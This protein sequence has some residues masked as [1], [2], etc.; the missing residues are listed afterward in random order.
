MTDLT[1]ARRL[2]QRPRLPTQMDAVG[3]PQR[4]PDLGRISEAADRVSPDRV[5]GA[6]RRT[7]GVGGDHVTASERSRQLAAD[8]TQ[9]R[10]QLRAQTEAE[11]QRKADVLRRRHGVTRPTGNPTTGDHVVR[12]RPDPTDT[13]RRVERNVGVDHDTRKQMLEAEDGKRGR[14]R[15]ERPTLKET[16][17]K[18]TAPHM[19]PDK[20]PGATSRRVNVH[21]NGPE[22]GMPKT[23]NP[24]R[25]SRFRQ[26][27]SVVG[28]GLLRGMD[29]ALGL[30]WSLVP[31]GLIQQMVNPGNEA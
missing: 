9:R 24:S 28:K 26:G 30:A 25:M 27:L 12:G 6:A 22:K 20:E 8:R 14:G 13:Q 31:V 17:S 23:T 1:D 5:Q 10:D 16:P 7:T 15:V 29:R 2:E 4:T 19:H 3:Q 21:H 18:H 11:R